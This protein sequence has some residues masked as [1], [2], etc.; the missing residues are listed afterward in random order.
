MLCCCSWGEN[1]L[2]DSQLAASGKVQHAM[3]VHAGIT[4]S[5]SVPLPLPLPLPLHS[6]PFANFRGCRW[7]GAARTHYRSLVLQ[8]AER[9]R[10]AD[11]AA[12]S[13]EHEAA[14][15]ALRYQSGRVFCFGK[16]GTR[17]KQSTSTVLFKRR[18]T[19]GIDASCRYTSARQS[20]LNLINH[21]PSD[22]S[23]LSLRMTCEECAQAMDSKT[24][25]PHVMQ[26]A[27]MHYAGINSVSYRDS[28]R[29]RH[30]RAMP[31]RRR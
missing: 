5:T 13:K 9:V 11:V 17:V 26:Y 21:T 4:G 16:G 25:Q 29:T 24:V 1:S 14:L 23:Y 18:S 3:E 30:V 22:F 7:A 10:A 15:G 31:W 27:H 2:Q 12:R 20:Q 6:P 28:C 8:R 19:A